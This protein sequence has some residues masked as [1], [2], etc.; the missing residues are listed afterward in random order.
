MTAEE[1]RRPGLGGLAA[2]SQDHLSASAEGVEYCFSVTAR[3]A[4][5]HGTSWG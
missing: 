2:P 3:D 4:I 1:V 5:G